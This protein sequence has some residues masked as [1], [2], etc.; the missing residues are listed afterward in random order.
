MNICR[1]LPP[2]VTESCRN[3][4]AVEAKPSRKIFHFN[5]HLLST[6]VFCRQVTLLA[7]TEKIARQ[8]RGGRPFH[9]ILEPHFDFIREQR[10]RRKTW[11]EITD[12]LFSEKSIRV[13]LYA[14]YHFY[15]RK[16]KRMAK[17]HWED[18]PQNVDARPA[19]SDVAAKR[20]QSRQAPLPQQN[21]FNR[22]DPSKF[23]KD[24]FT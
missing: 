13:T 14:P 7:M 16:L 3:L 9:S 20:P 4:V 12:L 21:P 10:R 24:Q 15:R 19:R 2:F 22:P 17:A 5:F 1:Q 11:R 8:K 23:N 6:T 18:E